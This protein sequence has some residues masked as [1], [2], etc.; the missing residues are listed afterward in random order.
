MVPPV[1]FL[2]G[3]DDMIQIMSSILASRSVLTDADI[4]MANVGEQ[5]CDVHADSILI[6]TL[7]RFLIVERYE[8]LAASML[9]ESP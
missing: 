2:F 4:T 6:E 8:H 7:S 9:S 3:I 1:S 5:I